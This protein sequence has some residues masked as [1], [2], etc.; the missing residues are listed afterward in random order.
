[1]EIQKSTGLVLSSR[2]TGE[3][4]FFCTMYTKEFGKRD[5]VFKGLQKSRKRSQIISEPGTTANLVY[6]FHDNKISYIV[7][8]YNVIKHNINIRNNLKTIYLLYYVLALIEKTTGYNDKNKS[9]FELAAAGIDNIAGTGFPEHFSVFF[10]LHLLKLHGI[11]PDFSRCKICDKTGYH[12]FIIDT[13]DFHPVCSKCVGAIK[14]KTISLD[15]TAKEFIFQSL[16]KKFASIDHSL[17]PSNYILDLLF[18]IT[19]FIENYYHVEI[20]PKQLLINELSK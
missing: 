18:A 20:K 11:L 1:M 19:L 12:G 8:E 7:N 6:Y 15:K 9:V 3:A 14:T 2:Q 5:F 4:D 16:K 13:M 17:Y 10:A